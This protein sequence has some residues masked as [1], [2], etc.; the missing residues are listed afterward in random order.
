MENMRR[1]DRQM[2]DEAA[3]ALLTKAV[4]GVLSTVSADEIGRAHV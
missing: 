2:T 1:S 4:Y 3:K